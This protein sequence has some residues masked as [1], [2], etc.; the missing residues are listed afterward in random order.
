MSWMQKARAD[1]KPIVYIGFGSITVPSPNRV[2][3]RIIKAVLK[4]AFFKHKS[5]C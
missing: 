1:N 5:D 3:S 2:T 4:S